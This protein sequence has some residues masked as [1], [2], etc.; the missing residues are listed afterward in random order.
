M[1]KEK[2]FFQDEKGFKYFG[3]ENNIKDS[4]KIV[5]D[6]TYTGSEL[7]AMWEFGNIYQNG[8][9]SKQKLIEQ[10]R[11]ELKNILENQYYKIDSDCRDRMYKL[12]EI[13][14]G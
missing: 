9:F 3:N 14:G 7:I 5:S 1:S 13:I 2:T 11:E 10:L 8:Y 6:K 12:L 4:I